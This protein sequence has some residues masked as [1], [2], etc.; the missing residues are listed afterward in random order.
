[1]NQA[2]SLL[3]MCSSEEL[4]IWGEREPR[5]QLMGRGE[6]QTKSLYPSPGAAVMNCHA[7]GGFT[8]QKFTITVMEV[9]SL[10][11][12][13]RQGCSIGCEEE[14]VLGLSLASGVA[15]SPWLAAA[16]L[17]FLLSPSHGLLLCVFLR[18]LPFPSKD[19]CPCI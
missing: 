3:A 18:V 6:L 17:R 5:S 11:P 14:S 15:S 2:T 9:R 1:M 4:A 10:R 16:S 12:K 13:G 8:Q 19:T 7:L